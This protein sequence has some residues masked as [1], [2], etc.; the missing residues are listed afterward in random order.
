MKDVLK[1]R[2]RRLDEEC[3]NVLTMASFIGNDFTFEALREV[4]GIEESKLLEIIEKMLKTGLL[5]CRATHG[6]DTCSFADVLI[7]DVLYEEVSPLRRKKLH[8]V[9]GCA[10][11][12]VYAKKIDEH[13]GRVSRAFSRERRQRKALGYFLKAGE[14]AAKVYANNEAAS[15]YHSALQ[16]S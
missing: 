10:L 14:K 9:V 7:R 11:E 6:E 3:Q 2:L 16:D 15:Y 12:K 5:K 8:G 4:T 13:L 1:A